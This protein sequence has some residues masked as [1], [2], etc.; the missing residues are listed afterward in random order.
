MAKITLTANDLIDLI[1]EQEVK[2][3]NL[4]ISCQDSFLSIMAQFSEKMTKEIIL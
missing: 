2:R 3:D 4:H 1:W